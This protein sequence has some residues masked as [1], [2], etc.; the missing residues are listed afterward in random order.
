RGER[1]AVEIVVTH[2]VEREHDRGGQRL[3]RKR[4]SSNSEQR[5]ERGEPSFHADALA[6][7][8][9]IASADGASSISPR[10]AEAKSSAS[11]THTTSLCSAPPRRPPPPPRRSPARTTSK[12]SSPIPTPR[13]NAPGCCHARAV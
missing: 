1:G 9:R 13:K 11:G 7:A 6:F 4:G 2:A 12:R 5:R 8:S 3:V 10:S